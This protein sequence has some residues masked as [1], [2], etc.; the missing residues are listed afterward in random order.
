VD[1][2]RRGRNKGRQVYLGGFYIE[3]DAASAYDVAAIRWWG[4]NATLN[5]DVA[6]YSHVFNHILSLST[7]DIIAGLRRG[8]VGG[9]SDI[10]LPNNH[11]AIS[12][13]GC[14]TWSWHSM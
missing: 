12:R 8:R 2:R 3:V 10:P 5:F 13:W 14:A 7:E 11:D 4:E 6:N 1:E 9:T